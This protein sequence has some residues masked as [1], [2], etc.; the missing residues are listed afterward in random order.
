MSHATHLWSIWQGLL[1]S[2]AWAFT[3]RGFRRFAEWVT[4]MAL[5][6]EEHTVTQSVLAL[7][8]PADWKALESFAEYGAWH[9]DYVTCNLTR[10]LE[11]APGRIWH[12]FRVSAV[13]DTKVHRGDPHV[14]GTCTF[15][16]YTAR[17]PNRATTVRAHNWVALGALLE[18][19]GKPAWYLPI[20][21][22][23]YF[24]ASQ[25]P[26]R[27]G[28]SGPAVEFRTKCELAVELIRQQARLARGKHLAI[29]D[30]AFALRSVVRPLALPEP[31]APRVE[32]LT[33][34]RHDARLCAVPPAERPEGKRGRKPLW[35]AP[36]PPPRQGGCWRGPW[37]TGA[38]FIYGRVRRVRWKEV[39]C[40]WRVL[41]HEVPVKAAVAEVE[42]YKKRFTL[43]TSAVGPERAGDGRAVRGAVPPG[44]RVPRPEA[45]AGLGGVPC[46]DPQPDRADQP[47]AV[48]GAEP[49]AAGAVPARGGR[50]HGLVDAAALEQG[51]GQAQRAGRGTAVQAARRGNPPR[52]LGLAGRWREFR[53]RS[54]LS[55]A[56]SGPERGYEGPRTALPGRKRRSAG[57][58]R[59]DGDGRATG[60]YARA[61]IV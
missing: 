28:M 9:A 57:L 48:G 32:F 55:G 34:L 60:C 17:C 20:T 25:L 22:R 4:A 40:L 2:F 38:A 14:W 23:L 56:R 49:D 10:L 42:G 13:D 61:S 36:L 33:R 29:F 12:G 39:V 11:R 8:R 19:P 15:H 58:G 35:G 6:V 7:D 26:P 27:Q 24:R 50:G 53:R 59:D 37:R 41:G 44:G 43:V 46:L 18:D 54:S 47:G 16:E 52:S 21:G 31:G 45:A 5:N 51:Q 30:G 1:G 3:R